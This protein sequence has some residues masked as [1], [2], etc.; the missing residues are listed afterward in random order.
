MLWDMAICVTSLLHLFFLFF[1]SSFSTKDTL[2]RGE[3]DREHLHE[4]D[5]P[6]SGD[7][8]EHLIRHARAV[9]ITNCSRKAWLRTLLVEYC[10]ILP[11]MFFYILVSLQI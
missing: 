6:H 11:S 3:A 5:V 10:Q 1:S 9:K 2:S 4:L 7:L 8:A